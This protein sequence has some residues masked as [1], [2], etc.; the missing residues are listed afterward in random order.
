MQPKG[1]LTMNR[2]L[3]LLSLSVLIFLL[4]APLFNVH[5]ISPVKAQESLEEWVE[6]IVTPHLQLTLQTL[7]H[8]KLPLSQLITNNLPFEYAV[9]IWNKCSIP[10]NVTL[11]SWITDVY[12]N[13]LTI[14][15]T[16]TAYVMPYE[17]ITVNYMIGMPI[18]SSPSK[19]S[20]ICNEPKF[21]VSPQRI[22]A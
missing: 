22:K 1:R 11:H 16:Y 14:A 17:H 3:T 13:N 4:V 15:P 2:R 7:P 9:T 5:Q 12:N 10:L 20:K 6:T 8:V 21:Y 19:L 18:A